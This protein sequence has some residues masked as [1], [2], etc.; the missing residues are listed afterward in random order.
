MRHF[1]HWCEIG[2]CFNILLWAFFNWLFADY[3]VCG[4]LTTLTSNM[5]FMSKVHSIISNHN[6]HE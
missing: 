4:C 1:C 5:H 3:I 6:R 2:S